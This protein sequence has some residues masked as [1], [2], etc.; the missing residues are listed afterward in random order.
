MRMEYAALFDEFSRARVCAGPPGRQLPAFSMM[1]LLASAA[2]CRAKA[3][4]A[5]ADAA[6]LRAEVAPVA[7]PAPEV[8]SGCVDIAL[9]ERIE[10]SSAARVVREIRAA[11]SS[12]ARGICML[13][14]SPGG[15]LDA[16]AEITQAIEAAQARGVDVVGFG[17]ERVASAAVLVFL[18]CSPRVLD[19]HGAGL[20]IDRPTAGTEASADE[21]ADEIL[22]VLAAK[23]SEPTSL[24]AASLSGAL[25]E[26][27]WIDGPTALR[28]GWATHRGSIYLAREFGGAE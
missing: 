6:K 1:D 9:T 11:V 21:A 16:T 20:M 4:A 13:V 14:S 26:D 24:L 12:G 15:D 10:R 3:R 5:L 28:Q 18:A 8:R 25:D 2:G 17:T 23:T 19:D 27:F 22:Q 7:A